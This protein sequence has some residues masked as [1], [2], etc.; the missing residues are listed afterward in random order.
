M[1]KYRPSNGTE[2]EIFTDQYCMNC[3]HCDPDPRGKKQCLILCKTLVY[4]LNDKEYPTEW[5]VNDDGFP[6]CT[7]WVKWDWGK[8][9]D[10]DN[11]PPDAPIK[12]SPVAD[13]QLMLFTDFDELVYPKLILETQ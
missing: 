2:G 12:P 6:I 5:I 8:D 13:N 9:G 11:P 7:E 10:P 4:D 3:I 1:K